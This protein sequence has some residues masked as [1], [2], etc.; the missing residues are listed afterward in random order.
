MQI[1]Y[2][3]SYLDFFVLTDLTFGTIF[4]ETLFIFCIYLLPPVALSA[5]E[6]S[7]DDIVFAFE[8]FTEITF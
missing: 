6:T 8:L 5:L 4:V 1:S 2:N 7:G 3:H